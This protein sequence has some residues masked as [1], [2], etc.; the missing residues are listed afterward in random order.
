[1][2][3]LTSIQSQ[4]KAPKGQWNAFSKYHYRSAEDILEAVKPIL[5]SLECVLTISDQI[6]LIGDRY[7]LK[8]TATITN[9]AGD[10]VSVNAFAREDESMKGMSGAQ[11]TGASSS[12][13]RKY[14]LNGLFCIDDT[15]DPDSNEAQG[16]AKDSNQ[17][18]PDLSKEIA[19]AKRAIAKAT[20]KE[21]LMQVWNK[22][23]N[24]RGVEEFTNALTQKKQTLNAS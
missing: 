18:V 13:A 5:H 17:Q 21:V 2:K 7:Y 9:K 11:I 20:T 4:L 1:M 15:K 12:Y 24:L 8:A 16:K 22:Y 10:S 14:A 6:E 3:E 23:E 19:A